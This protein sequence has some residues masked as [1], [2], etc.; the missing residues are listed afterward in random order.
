MSHN[1]GAWTSKV[2]RHYIE[3]G[4]SFTI[5]A[6]VTRFGDPQSHVQAQ[7]LLDGAAASGWFSRSTQVYGNERVTRYRAIARERHE[8]AGRPTKREA[9]SYF[10]GLTRVNSIFELGDNL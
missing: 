10:D 9:A 6:A 3:S 4:E 5:E 1:L 8:H 2:H 7:S